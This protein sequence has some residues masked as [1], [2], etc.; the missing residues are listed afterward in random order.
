MQA[1]YRANLENVFGA[2]ILRDN[3][4]YPQLAEFPPEYI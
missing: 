3:I 1:F 2:G 4:W